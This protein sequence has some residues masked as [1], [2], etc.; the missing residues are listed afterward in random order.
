[1][2]EDNWKN[3]GG[4]GE[5]R[6]GPTYLF[7]TKCLELFPNSKKYA[8]IF[9]FLPPTLWYWDQD[10]A[11]WRESCY[12]GRVSLSLSLDLMINIFLVHY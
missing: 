12:G 11:K 6:V 9:N 10:F 1:M 3:H 7:V 2:V 4:E 5:Q 8:L